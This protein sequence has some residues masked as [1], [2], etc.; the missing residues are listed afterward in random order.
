ML[1]KLNVSS[2]V[3]ILHTML[4]LVTE[5][6]RKK[7]RLLDQSAHELTGV[8]VLVYSSVYS[9]GSQ[10]IPMWPRFLYLKMQ[11][12]ILHTCYY[13]LHCFY[14]RKQQQTNTHAR[15]QK[16]KLRISFKCFR[17]QYFDLL[18]DYCQMQKDKGLIRVML[19]ENN[20]TIT[21]AQFKC[22]SKAV[23]QQGLKCCTRGN[24][25]QFRHFY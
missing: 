25:Y 9:T 2:F 18:N 19:C 16:E 22:D 21:G 24:R 11:S 13:D 12:Q 1:L 10:L 17:S 3:C 4:W 5:K 14:D 15:T 8:H 23:C 7:M 6:F 20:W